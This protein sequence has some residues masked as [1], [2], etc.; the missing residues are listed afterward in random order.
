MGV[1]SVTVKK[2]KKEIR[3]KDMLVKCPQPNA[4]YIYAFNL[5]TYMA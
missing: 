1:R 2:T 4:S 5:H 3:K